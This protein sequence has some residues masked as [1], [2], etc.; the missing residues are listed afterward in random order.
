MQAQCR[1]GELFAFVKYLSLIAQGNQGVFCY[2]QHPKIALSTGYVLNIRMVSTGDKKTELNVYV[3]LKGGQL[4]PNSMGTWNL[5]AHPR[6]TFYSAVLDQLFYVDADGHL[7]PGLVASW[8]SNNINTEWKLRLQEKLYFH[9]GR[10]V[11]I[12]D[13]EFSFLR[14]IVSTTETPEKSLA[15]SIIDSERVNSSGAY[16]AGMCTG[17]KS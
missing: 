9:D 15:L 12:Q 3:E 1:I 2:L 14:H 4:F 8:T 5:R 7:I 11:S 13:L 16:K 10:Q 17:I 6:A